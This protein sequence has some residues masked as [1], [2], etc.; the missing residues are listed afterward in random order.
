MFVRTFSRAEA[1][2]HFALLGAANKQQIAETIAKY[3]P[4]LALYLPPPRRPWT[5]EDRR[6]A[7]FDAAALAWLYFRDA[8]ADRNAA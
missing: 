4:A 2:K 1:A 6:M 8:D 5:S 3:I 7:I